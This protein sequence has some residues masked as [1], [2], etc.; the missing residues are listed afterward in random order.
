VFQRGKVT[1]N[2]PSEIKAEN[3]ANIGR[4]MDS[5]MGDTKSPAIFD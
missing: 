5:Y 1:E 3:F 4:D 2:L